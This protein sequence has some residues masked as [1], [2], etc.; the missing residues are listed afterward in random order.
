MGEFAGHPPTRRRQANS[1]TS[2]LPSRDSVRGPFSGSP[3]VMF[4]PNAPLET[5]GS[6]LS[7]AIGMTGT[8]GSAAGVPNPSPG[9][10][11]RH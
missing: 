5:S 2:C 11:A 9:E 8:H 6:R 1:V 4:T 3:F 10:K 7:S